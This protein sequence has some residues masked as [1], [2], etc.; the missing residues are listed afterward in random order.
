[1]LVKRRDALGL[2]RPASAFP[3]YYTYSRC[4]KFRP[5][6]IGYRKGGS[7]TRH[8]KKDKFLGK[9]YNKHPA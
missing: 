4:Q 6:E 3:P 2:R 9:R 7:K 8:Y 5:I 1:M